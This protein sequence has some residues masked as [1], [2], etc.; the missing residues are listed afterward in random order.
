[1]LFLPNSRYINSTI[2]PEAKANPFL[3]GW[4][5]FSVQAFLFIKLYRSSQFYVFIYAFNWMAWKKRLTCKAI[6]VESSRSLFAVWSGGILRRSDPFYRRMSSGP[7]P[8]SPFVYRWCSFDARQASGALAD[9]RASYHRPV[10]GAAA[11]SVHQEGDVLDMIILVFHQQ[12][13]D[14]SA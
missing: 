12:I 5:Y 13:E 14:H 9:K 8:W 7:F 4:Y 10:Q 11:L 1:M 6:P 2:L 3:E